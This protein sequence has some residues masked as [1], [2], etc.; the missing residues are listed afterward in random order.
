MKLT[1]NVVRGRVLEEKAD[2]ADGTNERHQ[3]DRKLTES[4]NYRAKNEIS[5]V[6]CD[7]IRAVP[8]PR[9]RAWQ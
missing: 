1:E 9:Y 8:L 4:S 5:L 3:S 6:H 7:Q 2:E